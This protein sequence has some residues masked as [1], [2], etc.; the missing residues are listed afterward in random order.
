M[1]TTTSRDPSSYQ[2]AVFTADSRLEIPEMPQQGQV[3]CQRL[4]HPRLHRYSRPASSLNRRSR[5]MGGVVDG[6]HQVGVA[7]VVDPGDVLVADAL[8]A[9]APKPA[10]SRVGHCQAPPTR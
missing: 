4:G 1:V 7:H 5:L 3:G 9:V 2:R 10:R 8:D 6:H